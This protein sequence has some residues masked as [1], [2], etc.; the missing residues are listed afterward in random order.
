MLVTTRNF[1]FLFDYFLN[2]LSSKQFM[3]QN[4]LG[5]VLTKANEGEFFDRGR[6]AAGMIGQAVTRGMPA[7]C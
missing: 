1:S 5:I 2:A 3:G 6:W 4:A 7:I